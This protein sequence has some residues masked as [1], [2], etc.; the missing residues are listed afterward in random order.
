MSEDINKKQID[1]YIQMLGSK[2]YQALWQDFLKLSAQYWEELS[3]SSAAEMKY[4]FHNWRSNSKVFGM[5]KFSEYCMQIET[6]LLSGMAISELSEEI[7]RS[8]QCFNQSV[9]KIDAYFKR[10]ER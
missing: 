10:K 2:K 5:E 8:K 1:E 6:S 9:A 7:E 4:S 3:G